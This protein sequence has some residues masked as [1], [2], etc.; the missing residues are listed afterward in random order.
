MSGTSMDSIDAIAVEFSEGLDNL[1][2][3]STLGF[4]EQPLS[5]ELQQ[6][7]TELRSSA[8]E[9]LEQFAL[10][11]REMGYLFAEA[12][13]QLLKN[14][15]LSADKITAIGSHGQ[16]VLHRS[17]KA[18]NG[19]MQ[20]YRS[21]GYSLQIGDPN[22]I[23]E[24]TGITTVADFRRRDIAAGGEGAPLASAFHQAVFHHPQQNRCILNLG[25]IANITYLPAQGEVIGFDCGPGQCIA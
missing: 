18:L 20:G 17:P 10:L 2:S 23:C 6:R 25:G 5:I 22:T 11:D 4:L 1:N 13:N 19:N 24:Q 9:N 8:I 16:T 12:T 7:L 21:Q 14:L 3:L 15:D